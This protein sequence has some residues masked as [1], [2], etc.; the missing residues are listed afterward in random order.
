VKLKSSL[1]ARRALFGLL[2]V[3]LSPNTLGFVQIFSLSREI[4]DILFIEC[5]LKLRT[6]KLAGYCKSQIPSPMFILGSGET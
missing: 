2:G 4:W 1:L 5:P 6:S 3:E